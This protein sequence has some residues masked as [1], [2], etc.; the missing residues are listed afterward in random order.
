MAGVSSLRIPSRFDDDGAHQ[1]SMLER[2]LKCELP[3][4]RRRLLSSLLALLSAPVRAMAVWP[5]LLAD[6]DR[7]SL[8]YLFRFLLV[9]SCR[10]VVDARSATSRATWCG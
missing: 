3:S 10:A 6:T 9:L 1:Q 4:A 2:H 7:R 8:L 5:Q